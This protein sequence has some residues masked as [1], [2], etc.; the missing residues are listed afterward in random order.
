MNSQQ[1]GRRGMAKFLVLCAIGLLVAAFGS[2]SIVSVATTAAVIGL[3]AIGQSALTGTTKVVNLGTSCFIG[4]GAFT[5]GYLVNSQGWDFAAA[6]LA[7]LALSLLVGLLVSPI[8]NRLS[9][10]YIVIVTVGLAFVAQHLFRTVTPITGGTTGIT[11]STLPLGGIDLYLPVA[12]GNQVVSPRTVY[13]LLSL[14]FLLVATLLTE[15]LLRSRIGRAL[16]VVGTSPVMARSFG[17]SPGRYRTIAFVYSSGL[18]GL[19]GALLIEQQAYADWEQF[20]LLLCI[21]IV[22]VIVLGGLGSTYS[23]ITATCALYF[24]PE[25]VPLLSPVLPFF[26]ADG[27]S[28]GLSP[29]LFTAA[30][31]GVALAATVVLEPRGLAGIAERI[32]ARFTRGAEGR[33][34]TTTAQP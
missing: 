10:V 13:F 6:I 26:A 23:V 3:A 19:A 32:A 8:A 9:G 34:P 2:V 27:G 28:T 16:R 30:L 7:A 33:P 5:A 24:L 11:L 18:C 25:L 21:D 31:F 12:L 15:N 29:Q 14:A 20:N 1:T 22:V 4:I 17:I